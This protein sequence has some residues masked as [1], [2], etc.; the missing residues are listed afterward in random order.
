M[1]RELIQSFRHRRVIQYFIAKEITVNYRNKVL[2]NLWALFD[3]LLMMLVLFFVFSILRQK[4][5]ILDSLYI[6]AGLVGWDL[7]AKSL[8]TSALCIQKYQY[9]IHKF[10]L[11]MSV[12]PFATV[13]YRLN[14]LVW[15]LAAY[16]LLYV[17]LCSF[18]GIAMVFSWK[19][20]LLPVW[21]LAYM[22]LI[23]GI[24]FILSRLGALFHDMEHITNILLRMGFFLN[25]VFIPISLIA[26]NQ[27][28]QFQKL[29]FLLNPVAGY[30][31]TFRS[32]LPGG[33]TLIGGFVIPV[34]YY[35]LYLAV[36]AVVLFF[37]GLWFFVRGSRH[38]AKYL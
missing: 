11:P 3:P 17:L 26:E 30:L 12:F 19:I 22:M 20:I 29:Y 13:L 16:S 7:F 37:G 36:W 4:S 28:L 15:G 14:D 31:I 34:P 2:G 10:P 32:C 24:S 6:L 21:V 5:T 38:F 35:N 18:N 33:E 1:L 23:L 27:S 8:G 25:P 9:I